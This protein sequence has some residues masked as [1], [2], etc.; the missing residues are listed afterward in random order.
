MH[1]GPERDRQAYEQRTQ[2]RSFAAIATELGYDDKLAARTGFL[3]ALRL[4]SPNAQAIA[5][6]DEHLRLD[7]LA[8]HLHNDGSLG[9]DVLRRRLAMIDRMRKRLDATSDLEVQPG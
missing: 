2:G 7:A 4:Q 6:R 3:S 1:A 9:P 5:R 8:D